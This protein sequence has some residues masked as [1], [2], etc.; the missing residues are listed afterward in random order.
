MRIGI[1]GGT[2]NPPHIGHMLLAEAAYEELELDKVLFIPCGNPPHKTN[3]GLASARH[4]YNMVK[5][6]IENTDFFDVSDIEIKSRE[7]SFTANTLKKLSRNYA[8]SEMFLIVGADS[9][10]EME[11]WHCPEKIFSEATVAAAYRAGSEYSQPK[12]FADKFKEKYGADIVFFKMPQM[13]ISSSQI[14]SRINSG[15]S[16]RYMLCGGVLD[17]IRKNG[18]Y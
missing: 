18:V 10:C 11:S 17:Y 1:F 16:V 2:F 14:R 8:K 4:R 6:S 13:E 15:K 3:V 9:L 5:L 12:L 7:K